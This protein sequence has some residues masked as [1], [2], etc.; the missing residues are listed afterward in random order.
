[1][2]KIFLLFFLLPFMHLG[3]Q[4]Y[5]NICSPGT[6]LFK[7]KNNN[8]VAFRRDSVIALGGNDTLFIS[9]PAIRGTPE[10]SPCYDTT[11]GSVLGRE[12]IKTASG[13]YW[14]FNSAGDSIKINSRASLNQSWKFCIIPGNSYIEAKITGL[15]IDS[16]LG[17]VDS[18]KV[19]S[20][21]AKDSM[22]NNIT[23][24]L[25]QKFIRLSKHYGLSRM[26]DVTLVPSDTTSYKL[27]GKSDPV[28]GVQNLL[29]H[30]VFDYNIGD[31]FHYFYG[32]PYFMRCDLY[33]YSSKVIKKILNKTWV[34]ADTVVYTEAVCGLYSHDYCSTWTYFPDTV[35]ETISNH[36]SWLSH[37]PDEFIRN[38]NSASGYVFMTDSVTNR[39]IKKLYAG[40]YLFYDSCWTGTDPHM[41]SVSSGYY[42]EGLGCTAD[43]HLIQ[44][45]SGLREYGTILVYYKKGS[46]TWGIPLAADCAALSGISELPDPIKVSIQPNPADEQT[47]VT[48]MKQFHGETFF[49]SLLT[50]NGTKVK[51]GSTQEE[52]F[53]LLRNGMP[54]GLYI[55]VIC[56]AQGNVKSRTRV[57]FK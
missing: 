41:Y 13:W 52:S 11:V 36:Y 31:E 39:R 26:I 44:A 8:L 6:T 42:E 50:I 38:W 4:D 46:E 51:G 48:V 10:F 20:F 49:Y 18:V 1:M 21:Q 22:N 7:D 25:N 9:Y 27:A 37:L 29:F 32:D 5:Q 24:K 19:I 56:D 33:G 16:V 35:T 53:V 54:S 3:A 47:L 45:G 40:T 43:V 34:G 12:V 15:T 55:L 23:H 17:T 14:F 30:D 28:L 2:K 57:L